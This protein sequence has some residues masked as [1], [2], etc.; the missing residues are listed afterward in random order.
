MS[1]NSPDNTQHKNPQQMY[2]KLLTPL[3]PSVEKVVNLLLRF[4]SVYKARNINILFSQCES[5][6]YGSAF[7]QT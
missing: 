3:V 1:S 5:K 4:K 7:H 2:L 6:Q